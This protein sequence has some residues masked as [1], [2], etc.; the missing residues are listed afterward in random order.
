MDGFPDEVTPQ[1]QAIMDLLWVLVLSTLKGRGWINL[2]DLFQAC[3]LL[4]LVTGSSSDKGWGHT[5]FQNTCTVE[6]QTS[7]DTPEL[8]GCMGH[9]FTYCLVGLSSTLK[10]GILLSS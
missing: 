6:L 5:V 8:K 2:W 4:M 9:V 7:R 3:R 1:R 10:A